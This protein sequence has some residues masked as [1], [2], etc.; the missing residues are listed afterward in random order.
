[1]QE[2]FGG[3]LALIRPM[4]YLEKHEVVEIAERIGLVAVDN[5]CPL[6][7][8]T[9]REKVRQ[10]LAEIYEKEPEAKSSIFASL[11]NV[12]EGYLL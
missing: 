11:R 4:A 10:I 1:K 6:A 12:R 7:G 5:L 2:L 9:R 8:N 3:K